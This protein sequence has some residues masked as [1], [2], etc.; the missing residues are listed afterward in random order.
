MH[1][2][3]TLFINLI[4][5]ILLLKINK[6]IL[7]FY[8][9]YNRLFYKFNIYCAAAYLSAKS[10]TK[11]LILI[12]FYSAST[13]ISLICLITFLVFDHSSLTFFAFQIRIL[14]INIIKITPN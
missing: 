3:K 12:C 10:K 6:I 2:K 5:I 9:K 14:S 8:F 4:Y 1:D 13:I 7:I 11:Q